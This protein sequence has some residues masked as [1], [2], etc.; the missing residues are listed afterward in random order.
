MTGVSE[1]KTM[2]KRALYLCM[3]SACHQ[4]GASRL[5]PMVQAL[6]ERHNLEQRVELKGAFC[7]G[8]CGQ[9]IVMRYG[10]TAFMGI[11]PHNVEKKFVREILP[12][13]RAGIA[14][15]EPSL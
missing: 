12:V 1:S 6:L 15:E 7:L 10:N 11:R 4:V 5:L 8:D 9:G 14:V 2:Q 13:I 3:G